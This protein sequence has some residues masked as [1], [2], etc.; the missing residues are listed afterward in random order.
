MWG[1]IRLMGVCKAK[2]L[3]GCSCTITY[4][5]FTTKYDVSAYVGKAYI[6]GC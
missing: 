3:Y 6:V 5:I 1:M 2:Y 4:D